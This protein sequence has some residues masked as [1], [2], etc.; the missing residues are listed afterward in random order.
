MY[1]GFVDQLII[2]MVIYI[3]ILDG[4]Q[5]AMVALM[6]FNG[7]IPSSNLTVCKPEA[8]AHTDWG[9]TVFNSMMICP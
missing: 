8:M 5:V 9:F 4:I 7:D 1:N 2:E 3:E 6:G